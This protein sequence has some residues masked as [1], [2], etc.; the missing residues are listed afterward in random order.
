LLTKPVSRTRIYLSKLGINI[1]ALAVTFLPVNIVVLVIDQL[2]PTGISD[3]A[4]YSAACRQENAVES[5]LAIIRATAESSNLWQAI[6]VIGM[7]L[8]FG[9]GIICLTGLISIFARNT[10]QA[11]LFTP[12]AL[13]AFVVIVA[14]S[15]VFSDRS[16]GVDNGLFN[17]ISL[18]TPLLLL[19]LGGS[20]FYIGL[21]FFRTKEF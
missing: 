6:A 12:P 1:L 11:I 16:N 10:M 18:T 13:I 9:I 17:S 15:V 7:I 19:C 5:C 20:F 4:R 2:N 8:L 3:L 21:H 14:I